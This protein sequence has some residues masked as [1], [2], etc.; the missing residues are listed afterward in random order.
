MAV[1]QPHFFGSFPCDRIVRSPS[2]CVCPA[3][4]LPRTLRVIDIHRIYSR[5]PFLTPRS[6]AA[7]QVDDD[8]CTAVL[9]ANCCGRC[10]SQGKP[11]SRKTVLLMLKPELL[12]QA[13]SRSYTFCSLGDCPVVYFDDERNHQF[14]VEDLRTRVGLKVKEDP[15]PLCYCFGFAESEVRDEISQTGGTS[16]PERIARLIREGLCACDARNPAGVCCLGE[17]NR[18]TKRLLSLQR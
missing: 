11:V 7:Y 2:D 4:Y 18:V 9:E 13:K 12:A 15:I 6:G 1:G 14:T 17:V 8:I 16:I 10:K 5:L 3:N